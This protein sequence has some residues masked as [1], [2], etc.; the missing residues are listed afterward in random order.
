[1]KSKQGIGTSDL[2]SRALLMYLG[3][4]ASLRR[5]LRSRDG[6]RSFRITFT[7]AV[8]LS[9]CLFENEIKQTQS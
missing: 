1:M 9:G 4:I 8:N 3:A 6:L 7:G 2:Y 5:F